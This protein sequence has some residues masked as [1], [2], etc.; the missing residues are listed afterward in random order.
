MS[1]S[2]RKYRWKNRLWI[3]SA[4]TPNQLWGSVL[5]NAES[6]TVTAG[7]ATS[8]ITL[9]IDPNDGDLITGI[10]ATRDALYV[11]KRN[12]IHRIV[13]SA[14][15]VTDPANLKREVVTRKI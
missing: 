12:S 6:W 10:F 9:D 13:A 1:P 11:F 4:T 2:S 8:A 3:V 14:L 5:G 7:L 15:P